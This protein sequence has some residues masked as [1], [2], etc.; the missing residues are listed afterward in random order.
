[1]ALVLALAGC[2]T[3]GAPYCPAGQTP[4]RTAQLFFGREIGDQPSVSDADFRKFVDEEL[5]TR[6]PDGLTVLDG[7][8]QWKGKENRLIREAAKVVLIVL[9]RGSNPQAKLEAVQ[10]AYKAKFKQ[11]S[12]L[13]IT[14][15][16]CVSS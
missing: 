6:F 16:A 4:L 1:M 12:V 3:V 15:R 9:P 5:T 14:Q 11:Q 10:Q 13:L 7:G 8:R 2:T